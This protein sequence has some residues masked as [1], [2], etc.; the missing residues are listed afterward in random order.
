MAQTA[1]EV[2]TRPLDVAA[3]REDFPILSRTVNGRPLVYLDSAATS[4]KP[5]SV[6][7]AIQG[8][9]EHSNAN[10]HRGVHALGNEATDIFEHAR[11]RIGKFIDADPKGI[12]FVRNTT[13]GLNL[14]AS[15][16]A[17]ESL[18]PGDRI[19]TTTMEHHSNLV[20]WQL[21]AE[22]AGLELAFIGVTEDGLLDLSDLDELLAPPTKLLTV[23]QQSNVLGTINPVAEITRRAHEQVVL[24][25]VDGA[26]S[27]PHMRV[28]VRD[29][30]CDFFAFSGHKMLGPMGIGAVWVRPEILEQLPP[31]LAGGSMIRKV[32]LEHS[33]WNTIPHKFE[34]GTPDVASLAGLCAACDYLDEIGLERIHQH[35]RNLTAQA[36]AVLEES[37]ARVFGPGDT[38]NRGGAIS[39]AVE[40]VHPH[41]VGTILDH[42]GLAVR[43]GHHCCQPLMQVL[44]VDA[45]TRASV[46]L[47]NTPQEV[48][49][50]GP[51]IAEVRR[52]FKV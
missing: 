32:G 15:S 28:S 49:M 5:R 31:F 22:R 18:K 45:T 30:G 37:G 19:V 23:T 24:V 39:F 4:Q 42:D 52:I 21:A 17:R 3:I 50:L 7:A 51:A 41:D 12:V 16:Y 13:E 11:I 27:V 48:E 47:Y 46:Y 8:Y 44:G 14:V 1:D 9:Y 25:C 26:Q 36:I 35:E 40:G 33:T 34:A 6:L 2:S 29:L 38:A 10:V 20:P 43:V